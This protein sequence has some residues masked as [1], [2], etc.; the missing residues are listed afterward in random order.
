[1]IVV[2]NM[3]LIK[4]FLLSSWLSKKNYLHGGC[5]FEGN[6]SFKCEKKKKKNLIQGGNLS[7][8]LRR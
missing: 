3:D 8:S 7:W 2:G 5:Q 4:T 1:M 6:L